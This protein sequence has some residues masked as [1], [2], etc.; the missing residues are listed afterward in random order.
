MISAEYMNK[1]SVVTEVLKHLTILPVNLQEQVLAF[2]VKLQDSG[3]HGISGNKLIRYAGMISPD[4]LNVMSQV[5][6]NDCGRIDI[7]EW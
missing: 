5:I 7:N 2:V 4:D 1:S 3:F 6:E